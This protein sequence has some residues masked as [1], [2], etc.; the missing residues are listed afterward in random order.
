MNLTG[1]PPCAIMEQRGF[2]LMAE[3]TSDAQIRA[4]AKYDSANTKRFGMKLNLTW[5]EDVIMLLD[6][7]ANKQTIIKQL[8]R[9]YINAKRPGVTDEIYQKYIEIKNRR[10]NQ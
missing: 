10:Q 9:E 5:D 1:T 2:I 7:V 8:L 3:K 6:T 4:N